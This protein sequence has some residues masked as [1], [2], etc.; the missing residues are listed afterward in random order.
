MMN[1]AN[2]AT[3]NVLTASLALAL[4]LHL[5]PGE[6]EARSVLGRVWDLVTAPA[7]DVK[8]KA[9][10]PTDGAGTK[11]TSATDSTVR[12]GAAKDADRDGDGAQVGAA[13]GKDAD[14]A[15]D[16][17]TDGDTT[18]RWPQKL[19][20]EHGQTVEF[21]HSHVKGRLGDRLTALRLL[22][23]G[24]KKL[25]S[26]YD[27]LHGFDGVYVKKNAAGEIVEIRLVESKVDSSRLIPGPPPQMSDEWIRQ[28]CAKM[29]EQGNPE[30]T[31]TARL[32]LDH[33]SSP[34]LKRELWHHDLAKGKTTVRQVDAGGKPGA[35]TEGWEDKLVAN[36]IERQC[37][38]ALLV[39]N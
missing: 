38:V 12:D 10:V 4:A 19:E 24:Y 17:A 2:R 21:P 39:C 37:V 32:I 20:A 14:N 22:A 35:V 7:A 11:G 8:T 9:E 13:K 25:P 36:E 27:G 1:P 31:E 18:S 15:M 26:K 5:A 34:K 16:G 30:L 3:R 33:M 6:A 29:Q 23:R 28:V